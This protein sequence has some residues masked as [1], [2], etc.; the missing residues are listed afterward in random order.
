MRLLA[1]ATGLAVFC[2]C[3]RETQGEAWLSPTYQAPPYPVTNY[4]QADAVI[5]RVMDSPTGLRLHLKTTEGKVLE[6]DIGIDAAV[7]RYP[8][9]ARMF[10]SDSD[11]PIAAHLGR[12]AVARLSIEKTILHPDAGPH[13]PING[14]RVLGSVRTRDWIVTVLSDGRR[15]TY[16]VE[17]CGR[18]IAKGL[19]ANV[20]TNWFR[21]AEDVPWLVESQLLPLVSGSPHEGT[22]D[23]P[24]QPAAG[25]NAASRLNRRWRR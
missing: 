19:S 4:R 13:V 21:E 2:G 8:E 15:R 12:V 16:S 5:A 6:A 20:L 22:L 25:S 24:A 23:H 1:L 9:V 7:V 14:M 3:G 11:D 10:P 18:L 17:Q